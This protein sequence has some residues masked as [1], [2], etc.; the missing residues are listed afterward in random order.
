MRA[1][2]NGEQNFLELI[3]TLLY[4]IILIVTK[5]LKHGTRVSRDLR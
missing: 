4:S 3:I 2:L 5:C 1:L